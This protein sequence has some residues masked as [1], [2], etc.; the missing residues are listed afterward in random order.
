MHMYVSV[1]N[2]SELVC[3]LLPRPL[4]DGMLKVH[5]PKSILVTILTS[6]A[7]EDTRLIWCPSYPSGGGTI[8]P[9]AL[10]FL[11]VRESNCGDWSA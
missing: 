7:W 1:C 4:F 9:R 10:R 5:C 3:D 8:D 11:V 6:N 2:F